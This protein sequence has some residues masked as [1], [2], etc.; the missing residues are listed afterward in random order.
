MPG[1]LSPLLRYQQN[2]ILCKC[3]QAIL[4]FWFKA[5]RWRCA[6]RVETADR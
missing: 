6:R 2:S 5:V 4:H 3:L 1:S